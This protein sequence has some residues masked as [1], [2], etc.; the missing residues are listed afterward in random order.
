[1]SKH[2][3]EEQLGVLRAQVAGQLS[4]KRFVHV[5]AVE[6]A[7]ERLAALYCP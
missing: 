2:F 4:S 3:T 5:A 1:M 6:K 7:A